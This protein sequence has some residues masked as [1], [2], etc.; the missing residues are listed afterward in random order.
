MPILEQLREPYLLFTT[1]VKM[2]SVYRSEFTVA[3]L[4]I[5]SQIV[6]YV[7]YPLIFKQI[8]DHVIPEKSYSLLT[9]S[10][11]EVAIAV[12]SKSA[13]ISACSSSWV[14]A[15]SF[16]AGSPRKRRIRTAP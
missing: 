10:V 11:V 9:V 5:I 15:W 3:V 14:V 13:A 7:L 4:G 12:V 16:T 8:I 1:Y 6:F 2:I